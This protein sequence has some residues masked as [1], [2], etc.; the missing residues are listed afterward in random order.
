MRIFGNNFCYLWHVTLASNKINKQK[1][2]KKEET[3][4]KVKIK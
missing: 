2:K 3:V 1:K 4:R